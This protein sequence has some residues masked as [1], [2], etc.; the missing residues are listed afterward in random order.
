MS[1]DLPV[2][3]GTVSTVVFASSMLPMVLKAARTKDLTSYSLGNLV[4]ANVGN[5]FHSVYVFSLPAGPIWALHSFYVV[6]SLLMLGWYLRYTPPASREA[7]DRQPEVVA[8]NGSIPVRVLPRPE[9][10]IS[11]ARPRR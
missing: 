1:F 7:P 5:G 9:L 10:E 11:G 8:P 4:L 3:A 2:L 6:T